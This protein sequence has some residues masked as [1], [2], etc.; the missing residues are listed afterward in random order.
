MLKPENR[1]DLKKYINTIKNLNSVDTSSITDMSCLFRSC[2]L[3]QPL[4]KWDVS[5]VTDM[6]WMFEYAYSFNQ[7]LNNWDV[8]RVDNMDAMFRGAVSFDQS[9]N[10]WDVSNIKRMGWMFKDAVKYSQSMSKWKLN[11]K[12]FYGV[13]L[14]NCFMWFR[15][16][17][18][19]DMPLQDGKR[20]NYSREFKLL[21]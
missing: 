5:N 9:L 15:F 11:D 18:E 12:C 2:K 20:L 14:Q 17:S 7:P 8:S 19:D 6:G 3:N 1:D 21:D 4:D 13:L 10:D 16:N